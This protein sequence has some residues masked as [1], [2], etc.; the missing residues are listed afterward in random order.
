MKPLPAILFTGAIA[1]SVF[2]LAADAR[3]AAADADGDGAVTMEE[4]KVALPA[5]TEDAFKAAD[6]DESGALSEEEFVGGLEEGT[7]PRG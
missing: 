7:L 4:A 6:A 3:F 2:A 1:V 5:L